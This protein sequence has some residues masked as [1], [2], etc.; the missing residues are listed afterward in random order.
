MGLWAHKS[1]EEGFQ[2]FDDESIDWIVNTIAMDF[3]SLHQNL[4]GSLN[5]SNGN[6]GTDKNYQENWWYSTNNP[7][8]AQ[9]KTFF[10]VGPPEDNDFLTT[11]CSL[12]FSHQY[13]T[14]LQL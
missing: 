13:T 4:Q 14:I 9:L 10:F 8:G 12:Y 5:E 7:I 6:T 1:T 11:I 3:A 2:L